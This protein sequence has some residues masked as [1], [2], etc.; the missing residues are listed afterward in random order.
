MNAWAA[1]G[2]VGY[3]FADLPWS[4]SISYRLSYFSGDDP[5]TASY[6]RWDP[7]LS[8]GNGEQWVQ[9]INHFKVVQDSNVIAHRIQARLRVLPTVEIVPQIWAFYADSTTNIGGNPALSFMTGN[10]YGYEANITAKWFASRNLYVHGHVAYTIAGNA[11]E[12]ALGGS[13]D[14][15]FSTMMFVRYAF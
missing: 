2:E 12:D 1:W 6:E 5:N 7:L 10:D 4:P 3:S 15:W 14:D 9:G 8:G 11:V 13:A